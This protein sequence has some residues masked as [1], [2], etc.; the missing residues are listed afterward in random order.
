MIHLET[1]SNPSMKITD[2]EA[3]SELCRER[4]PGIITVCDNTFMSPYFQASC[5]PGQKRSPGFA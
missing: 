3:V 5:R 2:L 4:H 1:P